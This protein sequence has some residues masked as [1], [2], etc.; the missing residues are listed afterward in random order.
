MAAVILGRLLELLNDVHIL[1][2][3]LAILLFDIW[4]DLQITQSRQ[5]THT[6]TVHT[7]HLH[8]I[9]TN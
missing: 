4:Y 5:F 1:C 6:C 7:G 2:H 3:T 8:V 9:I